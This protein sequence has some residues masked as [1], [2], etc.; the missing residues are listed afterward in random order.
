MQE[1]PDVHVKVM[2]SLKDPPGGIGEV[3]TPPVAPAIAN[4]VLAMTGKALRKLPMTPALVAAA[5]KA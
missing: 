3:G 5:L 4:A 2:P 1:A